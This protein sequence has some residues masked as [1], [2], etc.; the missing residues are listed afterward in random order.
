VKRWGKTQAIPNISE[1]CI[2]IFIILLKFL[3][4]SLHEKGLDLIILLQFQ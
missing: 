2:T 4:V 1:V 3:P